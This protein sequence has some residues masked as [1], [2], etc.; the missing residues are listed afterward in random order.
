[1]C[2][3]TYDGS[4]EGLLTC[5]YDGFYLK[6][7]IN[8][9]FSEAS[10]YMPSLF[11]EVI[12][13]VTD[14]N[15]F[16]K[17]RNAVIVKI[18]RLALKK[19]YTVYLSNSDNKE[20]LIYSYLKKA[21]KIGPDIHLFLN[22]DEVRLIDDICKRVSYEIHHLRGFIRF[23]YIQNK[24]LYTAISPDN[25]ILEFLAEPFKK[26]YANEFWIINDT[27]RKKAVIYNKDSY[28]IISFSEDDTAKLYEYKD[29]YSQLWIEYFKATT[30]SER[31]NLK[32]Q[33]RMMPKRY[34]K[35]ILETH[36]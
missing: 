34:W 36:Y 35:N 12:K 24:F 29:E 10:N 3:L 4:F 16:E 18:D 25:D 26:R 2:V 17:V 6:R 31:K 11:D 22:L 33:K 14:I 30:I 19:L 28:E 21:F 27:L 1:M 15:K 9:I 5:V 7:K 20:I 32:L 13:I 8:N 23:N